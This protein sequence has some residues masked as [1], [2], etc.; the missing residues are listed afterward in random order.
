[1]GAGLAMGIGTGISAIGGLIGGAKKAKEGRRMQKK[2]QSFIDDFEWQDLQNPYDGIGVSTL[3]ADLQR[4]EMA[5]NMATSVHAL[6]SGGIRGVMGGLGKLNSQ[7]QYTNRQ[8]G[9][10][11]DRQRQSL[12][13]ARANDEAN[14]R[15][16]VENRQAQELQGY[17]QMLN[18]GINTRYGGITDMVNAGVLA[19]Q[20]A[21]QL[22][23]LGQSTQNANIG[24]VTPPTAWA[25][26]FGIQP[27]APVNPMAGLTI[28]PLYPTN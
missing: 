25:P 2:A 15:A 13:M 26:N 8:I 5:K 23:S 7:A 11:L 1:M 22:G 24:G 16:M 17:G 14:Q 18:V 9:S 3:G 28:P 20:A 12:E 27:I 4:E 10:D 21:N 19:G 6:Q